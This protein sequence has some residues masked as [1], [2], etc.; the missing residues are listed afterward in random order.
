M[1]HRARRQGARRR[2]EGGRDAPAPR[3]CPRNRSP[4]RRARQR[5]SP[6]VGQ[7]GSLLVLRPRRSQDGPDNPRAGRQ[8]DR[9]VEILGLGVRQGPEDTDSWKLDFVQRTR[10]IGVLRCEWYTLIDF[11]TTEAGARELAA[12]PARDGLQSSC[13]R[14]LGSRGT[15]AADVDRR[16][17]QRG[18]LLQFAPVRP[19]RGG[20]RDVPQST[21]ARQG[22]HRGHHL[23]DCD[24]EG[25][26]PGE[27]QP[28]RHQLGVRGCGLL[29]TQ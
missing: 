24:R 3:L 10:T 12:G 17:G 21:T 26:G 27:G 22:R 29:S 8:H 16:C 5:T 20:V 2:R 6:H 15:E 14:T 19:P 25:P 7:W 9:R 1:G 18:R 28:V 13:H 23:G 4:D 11:R